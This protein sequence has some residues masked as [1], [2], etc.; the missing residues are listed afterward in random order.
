MSLLWHLTSYSMDGELSSKLSGILILVMLV[1]VTVYK[2]V[3]DRAR[4]Q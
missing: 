2:I 3:K 1:L 4:N